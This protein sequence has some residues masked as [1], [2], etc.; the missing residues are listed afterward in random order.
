MSQ[1]KKPTKKT[2][3]AKKPVKVPAPKQKRD[4]K[5]PPQQTTLARRK[6]E[7]P[8]PHDVG[9]QRE[10][11]VHT[12]FKKGAEFT[13]ELLHENDRLRA[14][15]RHLERDNAGLRTQLA[16][17]EAI[18]DLLKRIDRLEKEK[19]TLLSHISEAE[20]VST[21]VTTRY[22]EMEEELS[23][24]ANLYVASYQLHSTLRLPRV[25][26]HIQELLQ[27]LV[28]A[29]T[30]AFYMSDDAA[31]ELVLVASEGL[32]VSKMSRLAVVRDE[33]TA[34][35]VERAFL[36]GV[37]TIKSGPLAKAG[38]GDPAAVVPMRFDDRVVGVIVV[39]SVFEQKPAFLPVD[40]E[41]F[42]ML[43]AHA[44]SALTGA[45]LFAAAKGQLPRPADFLAAQRGGH[46]SS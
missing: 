31:K 36:T 18:R 17:D 25:V 38:L 37:E 21:R 13:E 35:V 14:Q 30:H 22:S 5:P 46:E 1:G 34:P 10:T 44:A 33:L 32:D 29:R 19:S 4:T 26:K 11:F 45:F 27:Q 39:Y 7:R 9:W 12:F 23:T 3:G 15:N 24:L 2:K 40:L 6:S 41:L 20:A 28:G 43:A 8:P 42:K 16:S